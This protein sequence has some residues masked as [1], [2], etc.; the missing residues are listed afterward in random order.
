M[1]LSHMR[2][3]SVTVGLFFIF[4]FV[5]MK[6]PDESLEHKK[7]ILF[8]FVS[9]SVTNDQLTQL[10]LQRLLGE[11]SEGAANANA[12]AKLPDRK[13]VEDTIFSTDGAS[14]VFPQVKNKQTPIRRYLDEAKDQLDVIDFH[15]PTE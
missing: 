7:I 6:G 2:C 9:D 5:N 3:W 11:A 13:T 15:Q 12:N 8:L 1:S 14:I 10:L 4:T